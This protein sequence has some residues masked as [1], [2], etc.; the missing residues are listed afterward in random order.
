VAEQQR[1]R[2]CGLPLGADDDA[3]AG[4]HAD[5]VESTSSEK[6]SRPSTH[7]MYGPRPGPLV[8]PG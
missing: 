7:P 5:C 1:C 8:V 3:E 2:F 4:W 6:P